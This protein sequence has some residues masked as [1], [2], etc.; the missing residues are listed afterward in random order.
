MP[1]LSSFKTI[2][3]RFK[4]FILATAF[5]GTQL[6]VPYI[7]TGTASAAGLITFGSQFQNEVYPPGSNNWTTGQLSGYS[8][9]DWVK[10]HFQLNT[11]SPNTSGTMYID[12]DTGSC[13]FFTNEFD[14]IT[15]QSG[16]LN[17]GLGSNTP[18]YNNQNKIVSYRQ[19]LNVNFTGASTSTAYDAYFRLHLSQTAGNCK[20]SNTGVRL[21]VPSSNQGD[22]DSVGAKNLPMSANEV[23]SN[24]DLTIQKV[25]EGGSAVASDFYFTTD[26]TLS[27][28]VNGTLVTDQ[29][30]FHIATTSSQTG[31]VKV[32]GVN[33]DGTINITE[34]PA[35]GTTANQYAL[36][37]NATVAANA[38]QGC[39]V[40]T[41]N[42]G[43]YTLQAVVAA[44]TN[45]PTNATC[46]F[47]NKLK[48]STLTLVKK[49][50]NDNGGTQKAD[51]WT[52][53]AQHGTDPAVVS[54]KGSLEQ[55]STTA[56]STA[57]TDPADVAANTA[58]KLSESGPDG[59]AVSK[60]WSCDG[61]QFDTNADTI[62]LSGGDSV[63]C[64]IEN[65]DIA[66]SLTLNKI[67][68]KD[69]GGTASESAWTLHANGSSQSP[70]NLSG[71]GAAG[72]TDV[73]SGSNFKADTYTLSE[74]GGPSGYSA[75]AWTCTNGVTVNENSQITLSNGQTTVC[76]ITNNDIAP[77]LTLLKT[78]TN[79]YGGDATANDFPVYIGQTLSSW[80][81]SHTLNAGNFTVSEDTSAVAGYSAGDWGGDCTANGSVTLGVGENKTC[82]ITNSQLPA[83]I[84]G[85]KYEVDANG[86]GTTPLKDW[87][88]Y[89]L[90]N[91][92]TV[93]STTT[94]DNGYYSFGNLDW[95]TYSLAECTTTDVCTGWT[96][97]YRPSDT[98][99]VDGDSLTSP[100]NNF[101][102][103]ENAAIKGYKWNDLNGDGKH[104]SNENKLSGWT[105][106]LYDV[107]NNVIGTG[108]TDSTGHY[109]FT[110]VAPGTYKVCETSQNGW[111]QTFPATQD[112][113]HHVTVTKS[114]KT[115]YRNFGNQGHGTLTVV[116]NVDDGFGNVTSDAS[117]WTW[118]YSG[119]YQTA[120]SEEASSI[121]TVTVPADSYTINEDQQS[122][123][124]FT[125]V[126]CSNNEDPFSV[127]QA[128]T[129]NVQISAGDNVVCTFTNTRNT[130]YISVTKYLNPEEDNGL[131]DLQVNGHTEYADASDGD[132]T[133]NIKVVTGGTNNVSEL[134][135]TNTDMANYDS[136]WYCYSPD[137]F[138]I[139]GEGAV[140]D[141]FGVN[142]NNQHVYCY[143]YNI[144]HASLTVVKDAMPNDPQPFNFKLEQ[145]SPCVELSSQTLTNLSQIN[146]SCDGYTTVDSFQLV[147]NTDPSQASKTE[148]LSAADFYSE[149]E[150]ITYRITEADTPGWVL[151]G[152]DCGDVEASYDGSSVLLTVYPGQNITCTYTNTKLAKVTVVKDAQPDSLQAFNFTSDLTGKSADFSLTDS[153]T[154]PGMG[155]KSFDG[156][157]PGTYHISE[158]AVSGWTLK[159][160]DC[161][162][163]TMTQDGSGIALTVS[164]GDD[165]TCTFVNAKNP[166]RVLG[167]STELPN[168]G[169]GTLIS[170]VAGLS[171]ISLA[172]AARWFGRKSQA[173]TI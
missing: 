125:S 116:K 1:G 144:R 149:S 13:S 152:L 36:D 34:H 37:Y 120:S 50:T 84:N 126:A 166:G 142:Y 16:P 123:Y 160:I 159:D 67:L 68:I 7:A 54:G 58:Y 33:P 121:N 62:T 104:Q 153:T 70:T 163:A 127:D 130:G 111:Q 25:V 4:N 78:V 3:N 117:G 107:Q 59:Y 94:N 170:L 74:T 21:G 161:G 134:A 69:N 27:G 98:T 109:A 91:G 18:L 66:P 45:T 79:G 102:N 88:I 93:T 128:E 150:G 48:R 85:Y 8:E 105:I 30:E 60:D 106:T 41:N 97:I 145:Y 168:T 75:S 96:Q 155:S 141:D 49:V 81:D 22:F 28:T 40:I 92:Q 137:R 95:G 108:P 90:V 43:S 11:A 162:D 138:Y 158:S 42:D 173:S 73:V 103:F 46:T 83:S 24:P 118:G 10:F 76:S 172:V 156:L 171:F 2:S 72:N 148:S 47:V 154:L 124:H 146:E 82:T 31:S 164:A 89:L 71:P 52:L 87:T 20:G 63:V 151:T 44:S 122:N 64:T 55:G 39:T 19:F 17:I 38:N 147:D 167:A 6:I 14:L 51:Q 65:D 23:L 32:E 135:G 5:V 112:Q 61:G 115:Y 56:T 100:N 86:I 113:C 114:G 169:Q 129:T 101:G 80:G 119:T 140:S 29:N 143:F 131:F 133:G 35:A 157:M 26:K 99:T 12:Y 9:L 136:V 77:T 110:N 165:I 53:T 139:Y 15:Q 132:T 57:T